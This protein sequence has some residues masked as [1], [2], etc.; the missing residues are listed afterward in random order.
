M[1]RAAARTFKPGDR[2]RVAEDATCPQAGCPCLDE[3]RGKEGIVDRRLRDGGDIR[4]TV[5]TDTDPDLGYYASARFLTLIDPQ[6]DPMPEF[7]DPAT[8]PEGWTLC[9]VEN[10]GGNRGF[11]ECDAYGRYRFWTDI[12]GFNLGNLRI[13]RVIDQSPDLPAIAFEDVKPGMTVE[14]R[15]RATVNTDGVWRFERGD[16][17]KFHLVPA[18]EP[19]LDAELAEQVAS[20]MGVSIEDGMTGIEVARDLIALVDEHRA[21]GSDEQ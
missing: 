10:A 15:D 19:D 14:I 4:F 5:P 8:L 3:V 18:P 1:K 21:G 6:E 9:E 11:F 13:V 20:L 7:I 2:V 17:R 12:G 16:E